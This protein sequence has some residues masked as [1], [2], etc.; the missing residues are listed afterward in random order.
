MKVLNESS[1]IQEI[2]NSLSVILARVICETYGKNALLGKAVQ[3]NNGFYYDFFIDTNIDDNQLK[4]IQNH[5]ANII[6]SKEDFISQSINIEEGKEIFCG[7][8]YKLEIIDDL[9][10]SGNEQI[11]ICK[12]GNFIELNANSVVSNSKKIKKSAFKVNSVSGAYWKGDSNNPMLQRISVLAFEKS[13]EL[14]E[15]EKKSNEILK[16]D[17]RNLGK[18]LDLYSLS[19]DIGLGLPLFHPNGAVVR[20]LLQD[21]SQKALMMNGYQWVYTPH[22]G[23]GQLWETSGHLKFYKDSMYKPINVDG[24]DYYLKPMSCP[25]HIEIYK[26][27]PKSYR[28]LPI[29]YAEYAQVYRYE[30]SGALQGL[31]RVRGFTQDDAHIICTKDQLHK[32]VVNC[33]KMSLYILNA[34]GLTDFKAYIATK[35]PKKSIGSNEQWEKAIKELIEAVN[36]CNLRYEI[37]EGGGAFYGPK[38]DLKINDVLGREWQCST[39]QFDFNLPERFNISYKGSDGKD[40]IPYM[41]HRALFGSIE[42][43]FALLIEHYAGAFPFWLSPLQIGIIPVSD[44]KHTSFCNN[45]KSKFLKKGL[46]VEVNTNNEKLNAKIRKYEIEKIPIIIIIGDNE[47]ENNNITI[48]SKLEGD[49]GTM[50]FD[51]LMDKLKPFM[52]QGIPEYQGLED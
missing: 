25:F 49:W 46:R 17:H 34:F 38:I 12:L 11:K 20:Y 39:I 21:F 5:M 30:L 22:I 32:E 9:I 13:S 52:E 48:R 37:D 50:T 26:S 18:E 7:Q 16:R 47:I 8:K 45:L 51:S 1:K 15:Y 23:R 4:E 28:D 31:T 29:R 27:N 33:L 44:I 24:E 35:P 19:S 42:R 41:V 2:R 43:F 40:H 6:D 36:E 3:T 10:N 14:V